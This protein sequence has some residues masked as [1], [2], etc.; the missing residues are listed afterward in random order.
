LMRLSLMTNFG[1]TAE[2]GK[3]VFARYYLP[4]EAAGILL[5]AAI[6]GVI[7]LARRA[8]GGGRP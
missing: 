8:P 4:F 6:V 1:T 7:V 3:L 5:L 2:V